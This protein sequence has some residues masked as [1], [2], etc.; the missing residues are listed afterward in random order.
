[1][2]VLLFFVTSV[3]ERGAVRQTLWKVHSPQLNLI[4]IP[5]ILRFFAA[6]AEFVDEILRK[7]GFVQRSPPKS[8]GSAILLSGN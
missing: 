7:L 4:T 2:S 1:M 5:E 3:F 8:S 6:K